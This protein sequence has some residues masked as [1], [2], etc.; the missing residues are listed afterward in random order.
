MS[1]GSIS[2]NYALFNGT[3]LVQ[4]SQTR[5]GKIVSRKCVHTRIFRP[6]RYQLT[7]ISYRHARSDA[8]CLWAD[9]T[10][11]MAA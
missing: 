11:E 5:S 2:M 8:F 1:A 3:E 4:H 10:V 7:A 9:Y 6:R